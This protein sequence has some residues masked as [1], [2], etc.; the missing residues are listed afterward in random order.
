[1]GTEGTLRVVVAG[2]G[3]AHSSTGSHPGVYWGDA[4]W[5]LWGISGENQLILREFGHLQGAG[6]PWRKSWLDHRSV[7][8][9]PGKA[10]LEHRA[11][12]AKGIKSA[13]I[14]KE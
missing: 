2:G 14:E 5:E 12:R 3:S 13:F 11:G 1:M 9:T 10:E 4:G 7:E 8:L 6:N